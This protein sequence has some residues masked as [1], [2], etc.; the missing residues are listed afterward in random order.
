MFFC[1]FVRR[2]SVQEQQDNPTQD[3]GGRG[4]PTACAVVERPS[5][6]GG[7]SRGTGLS[8]FV[9]TLIICLY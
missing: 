2:C 3:S 1:V 8:I 7:P 4:H 6:R 9:S 5:V